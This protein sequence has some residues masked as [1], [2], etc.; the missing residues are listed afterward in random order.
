MGLFLSLYGSSFGLNQSL[1]TQEP[2]W[3]SGTVLQHV[4]RRIYKTI[5]PQLLRTNI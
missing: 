3:E 1:D 4:T 2:P 5:N